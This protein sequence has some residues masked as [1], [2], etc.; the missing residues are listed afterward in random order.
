MGIVIECPRCHHTSDHG[1]TANRNNRLHQ[2]KFKSDSTKC[3][4]MVRIPM[5]NEPGQIMGV[6]CGCD[7]TALTPVTPKIEP[8]VIVPPPICFLPGCQEYVQFASSFC[9]DAHLDEMAAMISRLTDPVQ[10]D[11]IDPIEEQKLIDE[12]AA[13]EPPTDPFQ[14]ATYAKNLNPFA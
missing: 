7:G 5:P 10:V 11:I 1:Q 3:T 8:T 12:E 9:S 6:P 4:V 14:S 13:E 2:S